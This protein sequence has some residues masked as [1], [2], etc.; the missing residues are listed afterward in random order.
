M[1]ICLHGR[2]RPK[3]PRLLHFCF[4]LLGLVAICPERQW[5][6]SSGFLVAGAA[7]CARLELATGARAAPE[8]VG[9]GAW[10]H[11]SIQRRAAEGSAAAGG[12]DGSDIPR[13]LT[14]GVGLSLLAAVGA[15]RF[16]IDGPPEFDPAPGSLQGRTVL[17]TGANTGLGKESAIRLARAG[18]TV[19]ITARTDEKG[20]QAL[21]A[22]KAASSASDVHFLQL[23]LADLANVRSFRQR[24][25][26]QSYGEKL[27][28]LL[29]NA[30]VMAIPE[31][32][33]TKD[34]F[35]QQFGVNH[36]GHFT[37]V[38]Q[39]L[40]LLKK[41]TG[42][43]RVI[44]VS[45]TAHLGATKE[46]MEGDLM[47]PERYTQWGAYCQSKLANVLF[48]KELDRRFKQAGVKATAV[49]CHPGGVD[50][51]LA[52][53]LVVNSEDAAAAKKA[54]KENA[55]F[56]AIGTFL[57]RDVQHGA[58]TQVYLA[59]GADG[60]YD[61]SGGG[62][63]D[64]MAPGLLNPVADDEALAKQLWTESERLTGTKLD[65]SSAAA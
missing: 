16:L 24:F 1:R 23:D 29:N 10:P 25:Q 26:S 9:R 19:V 41:A 55:A 6:R 59:A 2:P 5:L 52:R 3:Q 14:L 51:D 33:Q 8:S 31:R 30:G 44:N 36:L 49:A 63:F 60:G 53:W 34:G 40:P 27:D 64:N 45:S 32:R 18:A 39:M 43:A 62:Y 17:I 61:R 50:T 21:E 47:A 13:R 12:D 48:A 11:K 54:R 65:V 35:E 38:A 20:L 57:T 58:N 4:C 28:V 22:I 56:E 7:G 46:N 42:F 15:K 37:L